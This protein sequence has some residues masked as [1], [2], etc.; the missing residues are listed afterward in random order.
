MLHISNIIYIKYFQVCCF[1]KQTS[2][3][4]YNVAI[5]VFLQLEFSRRGSW[6]RFSRQVTDSS[7]INLLLT[8]SDI[9]ENYLK[10]FEQ[11][12]SSLVFTTR[13]QN[14]ITQFTY[15]IRNLTGP[16]QTLQTTKSFQNYMN[17]QKLTNLQFFGLME[18]G[19]HL[20]AIGNPLIFLL[21]FIMIV[22]LRMLQCLMTDGEQ[23][24]LV[25]MEMFIQLV[26]PVSIYIYKFFFKCD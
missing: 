12:I 13:F 10:K 3:R 5:K 18:N 1:N 23:I 26:I 4:V 16:K 22:Q 7:H 20:L 19:K 11:E 8:Y 9:Q 24:L 2:R 6:K 25:N 21:G 15:Q 14:G 17:Q